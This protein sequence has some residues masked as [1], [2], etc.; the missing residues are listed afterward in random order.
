MPS[1]DLT[2]REI[3]A[4]VRDPELPILTIAELGVLRSV[5]IDRDGTVEVVLTPTYSGCPATEV[6]RVDVLEALQAAGYSRASVRFEL[7]PPWTSDS[8]SAGARAALAEAGIVPPSDPGQQIPLTWSLK[9]P[10]CGSL[11]TGEISHFGATSCRSL[12]RCQACGEP[13]EYFKAIR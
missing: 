5:D 3:V 12:W 4:A 1:G 2:A 8:L 6:M 9:C 7:F 11:R 13:F 10:K